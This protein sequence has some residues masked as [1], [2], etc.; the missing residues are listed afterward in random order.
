M[1]P[2]WPIGILIGLLCGAGLLGLIWFL[3]TPT[4]SSTRMEQLVRDSV[5]YV[6]RMDSLTAMKDSA[7]ARYLRVENDLTFALERI[8]KRRRD[9]P[10]LPHSSDADTVRVRI[11]RAIGKL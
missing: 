1:K 2:S 11:L 6:H 8:N 7:E 5:T 9:R 10:H 4:P 3:S